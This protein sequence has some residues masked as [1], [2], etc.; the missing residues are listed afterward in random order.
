MRS[1]SK[2]DS[3]FSVHLSYRFFFVHSL[4]MSEEIKNIDN[5]QL[6]SEKTAQSA[7]LDESVTV[8]LE[9]GDAV[10]HRDRSCFLTVSHTC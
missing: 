8:I 3:A 4:L 10:R 1:S 7:I 6:N 9:Y 2:F 5:R